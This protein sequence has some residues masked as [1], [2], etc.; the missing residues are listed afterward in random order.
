MS[1]FNEPELTPSQLADALEAARADDAAALAAVE[2]A[3]SEYEAALL[4]AT[5]DQL[6]TLDE[7]RSATQRLADVS[8]A[9]IAD[10]DRRHKAA[11]D[12]ALIAAQRKRRA[13]A[14]KQTAAARALMTELYPKAAAEIRT[15]I[16]AV[17][18]AQAAVLASRADITD[19]DNLPDVEATR[20]SPREW[21]SVLS[22]DRVSLWAGASDSKPLDPD[23][24]A[25]VVPHAEA[26]SIEERRAMR[27]AGANYVPRGSLAVE[28]GWLDC[29]CKTFVRREVLPDFAGWRVDDLHST[30][31]LPALWAGSEDFWEPTRGSPHD[32]IAKL[33]APLRP[34]PEAPKREPVFEYSLAH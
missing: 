1:R 3:K 19:E 33:D 27:M 20:S 30:L 8:R 21:S 28:H 9:K 17:A 22:E 14:V 26:G 25:R 23:Q 12:P 2:A 32:I 13:E 24:Q 15:V 18:S 4:T 6:K 29:V 34:Q 7:A 11:T 5:P 10:L 31:R 16:R